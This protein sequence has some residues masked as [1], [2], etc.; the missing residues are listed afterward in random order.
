M[1]TGPP[2]DV[3]LYVRRN[4]R[5]VLLVLAL[6][7]PPGAVVLYRVEPGEGSFYPP[8]PFH[9]LTG[10]HCAGC[11]TT[12]CLHALLH[13]DLAQALAYNPFTVLALP[14]LVY[15]FVREALTAFLDVPAPRRRLPDWA[16]RLLVGLVFLFWVLRNLAFPPFTALAP[17]TLEGRKGQGGPTT[18]VG[19]RAS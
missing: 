6:L 5:Y 4:S 3:P 9:Y 11:G 8:C 10:L 19:T 16:L 15:W 17:H 13:G 1:S 14:C 18:T 7:V 2:A 12:R